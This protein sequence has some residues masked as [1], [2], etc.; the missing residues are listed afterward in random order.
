M[1][2]LTA[3]PD[4]KEVAKELR[5]KGYTVFSTLIA[6]DMCM[7][8]VATHDVKD[9][10]KY[11]KDVKH[12]QSIR[13][14]MLPYPDS[15]KTIIYYPLFIDDSSIE[16]VEPNKL[17]ENSNNMKDFSNGVKIPGHT[18]TW[19]EI[20]SITLKDGKT[21]HLMENEKY[22]DETEYLVINDDMTEVYETYDDILTCLADED[23]ITYEE[24][25]EYETNRAADVT[26][27]EQLHA[28]VYDWYKSEYPDDYQLDRLDRSTTFGQVKSALEMHMDPEVVLAA[29]DFH[30]D[31]HVIDRVVAHIEELQ[32]KKESLKEESENKKLKT[33]RGTF[34]IYNGSWKDFQNDEKYKD[35]GV[36]FEH[37]LPDDADWKHTTEYYKVMSDGNHAIAVL[38][39]HRDPQTGAMRESVDWDYFDKFSEI[40][41]EYLPDRGEGETEASQIVTAVNKLIYKW[42]NDGDVYENRYH[43]EGWAN[44][45]S[46]Y[47]NW[48]H[49]HVP[50]SVDILEEIP[51]CLDDSD[52]EDLL[53]KLA[54]TL[55][56]ENLLKKYNQTNKS[57]SIYDC[58]GP[59]EFVFPSEDDEDED[60]FESLKEEK[61][62]KMT[63]EEFLNHCDAKGGNWVMM[64]L[65]GIKKVF[66][67]KYEEIKEKYS[68]SHTNNIRDFGIL[69]NILMKLGVTI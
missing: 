54:D 46:S 15:N 55:L 56:N 65:S 43:L 4:L 25:D 17:Q 33:P 21:Y 62:P 44:D 31:Q 64:I 6:R 66:P 5:A 13:T 36:W 63:F 59:F 40:N 50:E 67:E 7:L 35:W 57:G 28:K 49:E 30:L 51:D 41:D 9:V 11:L 58:E 32:G 19:G 8:Y 60:I 12:I 47:A 37:F 27:H 1:G 29:L 52:Y 24:K 68:L 16:E 2:K 10:L 45:L 14:Y 23:I 22:G 34:D 26:D 20:D 69:L 53:K 18:N 38:F 3:N 61:E 48:L 39:R 42:Y